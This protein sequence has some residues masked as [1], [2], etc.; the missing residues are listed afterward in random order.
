MTTIHLRPGRDASLRRRHPWVF[1]GAIDRIEGEPAAGDTVAVVAAGGDPIGWGAFSPASAIRVRMWSFDPA[2]NID[3]GWFRARLAAAVAARRELAADPARSAWRWVHGESDGLPGLVV[4]R[5]GEYLVCQFLAAG[6]ERWRAEIAEALEG[7][8]GPRGIWERSEAEVR[9]KEGLPGRA[10]CLAGEEPPERVAFREGGCQ[11]LADLRG[12]HKTGFYLDQAPARRAIARFASDASVLNAFAYSGAFGVAALAAGARRVTDVES[13]G[14][15]LEL[16]RAHYAAN[17][18][19]AAW[20]EPVEGNVFSVLRGFRA[21]DRKF[22]LVVLDPPK[23]ADSKHRVPKAAR[24][25]KDINLLAFQLLAPGGTLMTFSCSG[26]VE[27]SLF[28]KI[29]SDAALDAGRTGRILERLGAG[30]DHPVSLPFPEG[31]YLKGLV[32]RVE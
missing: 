7:L 9:D 27:S 26:A 18:L 14:P 24:G 22:D 13:S 3:A 12:G 11:F 32:V 25:Y 2:E 15:A 30:A 10:G 17:G 31:E 29:V 5:Y 19:D 21:E 6:V 16:A 23:F 20:V 8:L 1:S 4:D 28:Q